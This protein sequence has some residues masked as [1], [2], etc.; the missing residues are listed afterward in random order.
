MSLANQTVKRV[1]RINRK[2]RDLETRIARSTNN[3][4]NTQLMQEI[5]TLECEKENVIY[6][7]T[8]KR[9]YSR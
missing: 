5:Y 7:L 9:V 4:M 1:K 8:E 3:D 2:I 6:D